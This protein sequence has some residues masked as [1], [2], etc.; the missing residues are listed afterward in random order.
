MRTLYNYLIIFLLYITFINSIKIHSIVFEVVNNGEYAMLTD[1]FNEFSKKN[2]L[3]I[4]LELTV[5]TSANSTVL[6]NGGKT[7]IQS[8]LEN[9]SKRYEIYFYSFSGGAQF[10]DHLLDLN[11]YISPDITNMYYSDIFNKTCIFDNKLIGFPINRIY[12]VLY[13]NIKLLEEYDKRIPKTW[14]ELLDTTNYIVE[15]EKKK[16]NTSLLGLAGLYDQDTSGSVSVFELLSSYRKT[17]DSD[18]PNLKSQEAI[19]ALEMY[20]K[21]YKIAHS[22]YDN[23]FGTIYAGKSLFIKYYA[24]ENTYPLYKISELPGWKEGISSS[25]IGGIDVGINK[26]IDEDK[27]RVAAKVLEFFLSWE[28]QKKMVLNKYITTGIYELYS[29]NEVCSVIDCELYKNLQIFPRYHYERKDYNDYSEKFI[30]YVFDYLNGEK[31]A[32]EVLDQINDLSVIHKITIDTEETSYGLI[33]FIITLVL[34]LMII[35]SSIFFNVEKFKPLFE[36]LPL[37]FWYVILIGLLCHLFS[38]YTEYGAI[39]P[40]KCRLK[41]FLYS[42]GFTLTFVPILYKLILNFPEQN[43]ITKWI[44]KKKYIFLLAFVLCDILLALI[45]LSSPYKIKT[46]VPGD[47]KRYQECNANSFLLKTIV[48]L[49]IG[50]KL[51]IF[52]AIGFLSFI[53]WNMKETVFD[54]HTSVS[55]IYINILSAVMIIVLK[56]IKCDSFILYSIL[57]K[58]FIFIIILSNFVILIGI[59]IIIGLFTKKDEDQFANIRKFKSGSL[60]SNSGISSQRSTTSSSS[61]SKQNKYQRIIGYHYRTKLRRISVG[62][63]LSKMNPTAYTNSELG[64]PF[65]RRRG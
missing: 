59:R 39:I 52:V 11:D 26:Y 1:D 30:N 6:N 29:D 19:D 12:S 55:T 44:T 4:T 38:N 17:V 65:Y 24:Y 8:L 14:E 31:T 54:V 2:N 5:L 16:N 61:N 28:E 32:V 46:I 63:L 57:N 25:N 15:E 27:K 56:F 41:V 37:D 35:G 3:D 7:T 22:G 49:S 9:K 23:I 34:S 33:L 50:Y 48:Y 43:S 47:G 18:Y 51:I 53:E 62:P 10:S 20:K 40:S 60:Q 36:F 21:I 58:V 42:V 64:L 45:S 13:S